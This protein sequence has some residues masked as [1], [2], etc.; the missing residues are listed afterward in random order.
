MV[1]ESM[2]GTLFG[3]GGCGPSA[4]FFFF[5]VTNSP[6]ILILYIL[7][8]KIQ[9]FGPIFIHIKG[10]RNYQMSCI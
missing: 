6:Y 4:F 2:G 1:C 10:T 3:Q 5:F 8:K 9:N 7:D